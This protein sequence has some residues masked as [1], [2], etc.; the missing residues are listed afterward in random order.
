MC[1]HVSTQRGTV[2]SC[3]TVERV[4]NIEKMTADVKYTFQHFDEA[5]KKKMKICSEDGYIRDKPNP[6]RW[7]DLI[8]NNN[9]FRE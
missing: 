4:T 8:E 9:N 3:S 5:M 2:L 7:A 1:Y 6:D